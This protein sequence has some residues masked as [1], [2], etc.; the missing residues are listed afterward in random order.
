M[1]EEIINRFGN[2][3]EVISIEEDSDGSSNK[4]QVYVLENVST[5]RD[6]Y[7]KKFEAIVNCEKD[8]HVSITH[9]NGL[10]LKEKPKDVSLEEV[11]WDIEYNLSGKK[12]SFS[13][14]PADKEVFVTCKVGDKKYQ[15]FAETIKEAVILVGHEI[16]SSLKEEVETELNWN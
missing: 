10:A 6:E 11:I 1:A 12:F 3:W 7:G 16:Y 14:S 15:S 8:T 13:C 2:K 9:I 4:T 5:T